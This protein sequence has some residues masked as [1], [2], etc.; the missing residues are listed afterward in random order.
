MAIK[1]P[2][3]MYH[4]CY[5]G[6]NLKDLEGWSLSTELECGG[7]SNLDMHTWHIPGAY[8]FNSDIGFLKISPSSD[9]GRVSTICR[10]NPGFPLERGLLVR[11]IH[12]YRLVLSLSIDGQYAMS[13]GP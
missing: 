5:V 11:I 6:S 2:L 10:R 13:R 9:G 4:I 3:R 7:Q 1:W 12:P 8:E